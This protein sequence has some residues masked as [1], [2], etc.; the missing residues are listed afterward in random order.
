MKNIIIVGIIILLV[1]CILAGYF[2][3]T[4]Y[5][6]KERSQ[7]SKIQSEKQAQEIS[8]NLTETLEDISKILDE[9]ERGL[10]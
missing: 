1:V 5:V 4:G 7:N 10:S 8:E 9:I 2:S 3:L 6:I